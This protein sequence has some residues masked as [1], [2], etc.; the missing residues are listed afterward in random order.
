MYLDDVTTWR[1]TTGAIVV[2][3]AA[4]AVVWSTSAW[5]DAAAESRERPR[6]VVA[7]CSKRSSQGQGHGNLNAWRAARN[8]VVGPLAMVGAAEIPGT[9]HGGFHGNKFPLYLLAGHRVTL[10]L[11]PRTRGHAGIAY[12][13]LPQGDVGVA[14]AHRVLT[15]I[16]C[17][18]GEY[19]PNSGGP[20][21]RASFWAGGIVADAPRCVPLLM[22]VDK[23]RAP[24]RAVIHLG[25]TDCA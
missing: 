2:M 17:R 7:D 8:L 15:L 19:S 18:R 3:A 24:R 6:G 10:S 14:E 13:P 21:G 5:A 20:A 16:A 22:W 25:V 1:A 12:G 9:Y 4:W 23:E 11:T